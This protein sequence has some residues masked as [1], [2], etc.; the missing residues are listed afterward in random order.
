MGRH[1]HNHNTFQTLDPTSRSP[2]VTKISFTKPGPGPSFWNNRR[3][4]IDN[5][6]GLVLALI[7][8]I[9]RQDLAGVRALL[10]SNEP[11]AALQSIPI[12]SNIVVL[13]NSYPGVLPNHLISFALL[14]AKRDGNAAVA[15]YLIHRHQA[16]CLLIPGFETIAEIKERAQTIDLKDKTS[17]LSSIVDFALLHAQSDDPSQTPTAGH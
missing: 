1:I 16:L 14:V 5:T 4:Q 6:P 10:E 17:L 13:I 2:L 8:A 12:P 3:N 9:N 15:E 7:D 11:T